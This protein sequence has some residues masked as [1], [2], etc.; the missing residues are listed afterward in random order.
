MSGTPWKSILEDRTFPG[1]L[2]RCDTVDAN[3]L[4]IGRCTQAGVRTRSR[5]QKCF[6]HGGQ[7]IQGRIV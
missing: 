4:R 2:T 3:L 7:E 5:L 1:L 6:K